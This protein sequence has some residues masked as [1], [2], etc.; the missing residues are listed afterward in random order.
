MVPE[1]ANERQTPANGRRVAL[2]D[3]RPEPL[4]VHNERCR[5]DDAISVRGAE[6]FSAQLLRQS[7]TTA[8]RRGILAVRRSDAPIG[9]GGGGSG[10][11]SRPQ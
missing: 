4:R 3:R 1:P 5:V 8:R 11:A 9:V 10:G 6:H 2:W 7:G